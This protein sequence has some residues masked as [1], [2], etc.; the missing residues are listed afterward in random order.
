MI[1]IPGKENVT[2]YMSRHA[3]QANKETGTEKYIRAITQTDHAIILEKIAEETKHDE[4]LQKVQK[5]IRTGR[6][7]KQDQTLKPYIDLQ[8][9]LY[10]SEEVI[11]RLDK[12]TPP[13]SLRTK[14]I[15]IAH[16][17]GHLGLSKT[18]EMIRHKYWWPRMNI[19]IETIVKNCFECQANATS[20]NDRT[21]TQTMEC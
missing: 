11:L 8:A 13:V 1:H 16:K 18:K 9:E 14:I 7:D 12:I 4:Q 17:Q 3:L 2:D 10:E 21:P 19:E 5:A 20:Q 6:W 15:N